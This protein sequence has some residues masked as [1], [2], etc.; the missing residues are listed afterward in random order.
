MRIGRELP[1]TLLEDVDP[2][3]FFFQGDFILDY[4]QELNNNVIHH[5]QL[6]TY[7][8]AICRQNPGLKA[9]EIGA[10]TGASTDHILQALCTAQ[11]ESSDLN[12]L[13]YDFTDI[14]PALFEAVKAN[15]EWCA[16]KLNF[17]VLDVEK[18]VQD[19]G[20]EVGTYDLMFAASVCLFNE[21]P[22]N[23]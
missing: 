12:C 21:K 10:G 3:N 4:Y 16:A 22:G 5:E 8:Q 18:D 15:F 17:G 11:N 6:N 9:I 19:Q 23:Y 14:S 2:F 13:S 20:Y 1:R 7:L